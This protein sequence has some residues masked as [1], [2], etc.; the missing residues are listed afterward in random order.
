MC[1]MAI[2]DFIRESG[3]VP[4][5]GQEM[6][7]VLHSHNLTLY[8]LML[9]CTQHFHSYVGLLPSN[10]KQMKFLE[11]SLQS[12][13]GVAPCWNG[14]D[15]IHFRATCFLLLYVSLH[16][17]LTLNDGATSLFNGILNPGGYKAKWSAAKTLYHISS[18]LMTNPHSSNWNIHKLVT[19]NSK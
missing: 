16:R 9:K 13:L 17:S 18:P 3:T 14:K 12:F 2:S 11:V 7:Q 10:G 19:E 8:I 4:C 6:I 5:C 1:T 15:N